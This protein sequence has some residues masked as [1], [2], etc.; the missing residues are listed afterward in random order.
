MTTSSGGPSNKRKASGSGSTIIKSSRRRLNPPTLQSFQVSWSPDADT[1]SELGFHIIATATLN[2]V[3]G[4]KIIQYFCDGLSIL[5][6]TDPG[7]VQY[8]MTVFLEDQDESTA[9]TY[10]NTVT[11]DDA[12]GCDNNHGLAGDSNLKYVFGAY[13]EVTFQNQVLLHTTPLFG[14][15]TGTGPGR[16]F[17]PAAQVTA[18]WNLGTNT[19]AN[20]GALVNAFPAWG[21]YPTPQVDNA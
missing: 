20:Q 15:I 5:A 2:R 7:N 18:I 4:V 11:Y 9:D 14:T 1:A 8:Y 13:W 6:G 19:W 3:R 10:T 17:T 21:N 12:P 16:T